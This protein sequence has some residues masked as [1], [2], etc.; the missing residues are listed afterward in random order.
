MKGS[1]IDPPVEKGYAVIARAWRAG[2]RIDLTLPMKVQRIKACEE[3]AATRGQAALRYGPL[4]YAFESVDQ[5]LDKTLD[6]G[7][8]L[9]TEWRGDL[10]GG[11][12]VVKGAWADGS[13]LTAIPYYA[14]ANRP[15]TGP[16]G[17]APR[18]TVWIRGR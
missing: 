14:R 8:P 11:V 1:A 12:T 5:D 3:I 9:S 13:S 15:G 2:D 4:V 16:A 18:S 17:G 6:P 7:A 10:L